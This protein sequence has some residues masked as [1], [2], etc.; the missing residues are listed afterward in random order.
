MSAIITFKSIVNM[1]Q[2]GLSLS[3]LFSR[4][5]SI[6]ATL[7]L[8]YAQVKQKRDYGSLFLAAL[9]TGRHYPQSRVVISSDK[10]IHCPGVGLR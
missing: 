3:E 8:H 5:D 4:Q 9:V 1:L 2:L 6:T 10:L 7:Q